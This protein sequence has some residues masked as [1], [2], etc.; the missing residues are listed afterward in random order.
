M[1]G[2]TAAWKTL[3]WEPGAFSEIDKACCDLLECRYPDVPNLGDMTADDFIDR[4]R[5]VGPYD[6]ICGGTPCQSFSI[7]GLRQGLKDERGNLTLRFVE[8]CNEVDTDWIVWENVRG[9][10]SDKT[11]AFGCLLAGLVGESAPLIAPGGKWTDAGYVA[12][13]Q[14]TVAWRVFDAQYFRLAQRRRRV[15][16]IGVRA[17][18][19]IHPG[20]VLFEPESVRR[21]SPPGRK[22]GEGITHDVAPSIGASGRGFQR[23]GGTRGQDPVVACPLTKQSY[24]DHLSRES[25]LVP[26]ISGSIGSRSTGGGWNDDLDRAGAFVPEISH[27]L[28]SRHDS[29]EDGT[30]R[31]TP[32]VPEMKQQNYI[33]FEPGIASRDGGH[34]YDNI[35]RTIRSKPGDNKMTVAYRTSGNCGVMEQGNKTAALT[36]STDRTS[37]IVQQ[38]M[39]VRRLT[40]RECERLMGFPDDYTLIK[41][42]NGKP[43]ADGPR[44]RMIGNSWAVSVVRWIG[45]RIEKAKAGLPGG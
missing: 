24:G 22:A 27:S 41:R 16:V 10:L 36:Q 7:S 45:E 29:G 30:G 17:G 4:A 23:A 3:G 21:H 37:Q 8:I 19:G 33:A 32:I 18:I 28:K 1:E 39:A 34:V 12:G 42:K 5:K 2:A 35:S 44:Y 9:I 20:Q 11:N 25:L 15:F 38:F 6:I 31:G 26:E 40:P 14:R 43:I 13:P